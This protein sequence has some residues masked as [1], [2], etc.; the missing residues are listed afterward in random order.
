MAN[1]TTPDRFIDGSLAAENRC[2]IKV[3]FSDPLSGQCIDKSERLDRKDVFTGA[4][5][6][7]GELGLRMMRGEE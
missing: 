2:V 1:P 4:A 6:V 5:K 3:F 7:F